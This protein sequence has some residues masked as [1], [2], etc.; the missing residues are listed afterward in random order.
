MSDA[1][2]AGKRKDCEGTVADCSSK[3]DDRYKTKRIGSG[4]KDVSKWTERAF[5]G[6][7]TVRTRK[8]CV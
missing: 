8:S 7:E 4:E 1:G 6:K 5:P 2:L 3:A